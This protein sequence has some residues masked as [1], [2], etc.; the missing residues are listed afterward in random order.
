MAELWQNAGQFLPSG[1]GRLDGG[2]Q[3]GIGSRDL[4][5]TFSF[6][7]PGDDLRCLGLVAVVLGADLAQRRTDLALVH[8]MAVGAAFTAQRVLPK[9]STARE[10]G[11]QRDAE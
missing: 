8:V 5:M 3:L 2:L 4:G 6:L 11:G 7:H 9:R 10:R 1:E